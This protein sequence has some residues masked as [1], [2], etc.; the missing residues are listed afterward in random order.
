M[1]IAETAAHL[2]NLKRPISNKVVKCRMVTP[3]F[4]NFNNLTEVTI[5]YFNSII[6]QVVKILKVLVSS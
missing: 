6:I 4:M 5:S 3:K 2:K 1:L